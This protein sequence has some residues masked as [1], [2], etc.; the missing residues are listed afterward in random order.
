MSRAYTADTLAALETSQAQLLR[1]AKDA[2][3]VAQPACGDLQYLISAKAF[4]AL[5][6][7][8]HDAAK[9]SS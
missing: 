8:I 6:K 3:G 9:V 2:V 7:A 5:L 4:D 1:A